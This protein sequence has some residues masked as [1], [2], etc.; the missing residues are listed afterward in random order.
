MSNTPKL[1]VAAQF[2]AASLRLDVSPPTAVP[3]NLAW[4]VLLNHVDGH[5]LTPA[6]Y[7]AWKA[8]GL[9]PQV[10]EN[11]RIRLE[12]AYQD[13]AKRQMAVRAELLEIHQLLTNAGVE[14]V[15]LKGWP[16]AERLY[17]N[18]AERLL[19]DHDLLVPE[20]SLATGYNALLAAGFRPLPGDDSAV[21]KHARPVWRNDGYQWNGY[22]F[23]PEYPRPVELHLRL[24]D[25]QWRGLEVRE[26]PD[27][28]ADARVRT[29]AG[30]PMRMLSNEKTFVH[31][32]MHY[33]GHLIERE[34]RLSQLLDVALYIKLTHTLDWQRMLTVADE[35]LYRF[36]Y[37]SLL[38]A[39][40][41]F[42]A[43]QPPAE[44]WQALEAAT[45]VPFRQWLQA[46][47]VTDALTTDFRRRHRGKDYQRAFG[48]VEDDDSGFDYKGRDYQLTFL[49]ARS[50]SE[51]AGIL[52]Y[53]AL[54]PG[55]QLRAKYNSPERWST[56]LLYPR[57]FAERLSEYGRAF[58]NRKH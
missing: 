32:A 28:W 40:R 56:P 52:K 50:L 1:L 8:K 55:E 19:R 3:D 45:P 25:A 11:Y 30:A 16:L 12:V 6:L 47:G 49:A 37:A 34:A 26:L 31:L 41:I 53:A 27:L 22:L 4:D 39:E 15:V 33:A 29:V 57:H 48:E 13:N 38:L 24:W 5:T 35:S 58:L 23:D 51:R 7:A 36:I 18:P 10:P 54:P 17:A 14:H 21:D 43:P 2:I 20:S 44:I 42:G 9:L 46:E